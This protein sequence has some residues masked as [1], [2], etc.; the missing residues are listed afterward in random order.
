MR[1]LPASPQPQSE[2]ERFNVN[3]TDEQP[4]QSSGDITIR[5]PIVVFLVIK[6]TET[7][8]GMFGPRKR[9][10]NVFAETPGQTTGFKI[11]NVTRQ[12][13]DDKTLLKKTDSL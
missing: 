6:S 11:I 12:T 5:E 13:T 9:L 4:S 3:R 8:E 7:K 2:S 10:I 1:L